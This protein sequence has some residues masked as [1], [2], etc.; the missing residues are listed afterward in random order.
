MPLTLREN[1]ALGRPDASFC[2]I[3]D[4]AREAGVSDFAASLPRDFETN[5]GSATSA[6]TEEQRR[7]IAL[8]RAF[9]ED[10][11]VL[12][13]EQELVDDRALARTV[14]RLRRGRR[15]FVLAKGP[16]YGGDADS[17]MLVADG[18]VA[19]HGRHE[20]LIARGGLYASLCNGET[21]LEQ[22]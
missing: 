3:E 17:V 18:A 6:L 14:E 12:V 19:E 21:T 13:I 20:E 11:P 9:L 2:E 15:T 4:A 8:A 5:V 16:A 1:I 10:P 22:A 7:R